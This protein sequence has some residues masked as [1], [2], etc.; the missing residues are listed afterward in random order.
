MLFK[1][2][3]FSL[4]LSMKKRLMQKKIGIISNPGELPPPFPFFSVEVSGL[5]LE[6]G[7]DSVDR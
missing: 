7:W 2:V 6:T 5:D 1:V 3:S 4:I